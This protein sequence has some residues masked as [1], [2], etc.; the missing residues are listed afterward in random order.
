LTIE[1]C[2]R[3]GVE[4]VR[5]YVAFLF[6]RHGKLPTVNIRVGLPAHL[7]TPDPSLWRQASREVGGPRGEALAKGKA[8]GAAD[9]IDY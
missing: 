3:V 9:G 6:V 8:G 2:V 1:A 7:S 4:A 5:L